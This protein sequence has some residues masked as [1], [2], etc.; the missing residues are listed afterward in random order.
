M[1]KL[2]TFSALCILCI[3]MVNAQDLKPKKDKATK[4]YG[5]VNKAKEFVIQPAWDDAEKFKDGFAIVEINKMKG[6]INEKGTV[7][8]E[9]QFYDIEKFKSNIA[10][11]VKNKK[12]GF[13]DNTGKILCEPKFDELKDDFPSGVFH[14]KIGEVW[15]L[16]GIGGK[17]LFEPQFLLRLDF[18]R[19]G[20]A[21]CAKKTGTETYSPTYYGIVKRDGSTVLECENFS[22]S[23]EGN[24][25]IISDKSGKW[26]I[27]DNNLKAIS[28]EFDNMESFSSGLSASRK[29]INDGIIAAKRDNKWGFINEKGETIIPFKFDEIGSE[30]YS[31]SQNLCAVKVGSKWGYI[32]KTGKYF[33]EPQFEEAKRFINALGA[34][35]AEV[36]L[37]G[38][39]YMLSD[40]GE[41]KLMPGQ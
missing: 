15:G 20:W 3:A 17:E 19:N 36:V 1:R 8:I 34:V 6:L 33:K 35:G 39:K 16:I 26:K 18:D 13:V 40:K 9:P 24:R 12:L 14:T 23:S 28:T 7:L 30:G 38:K 29:Y 2:V 37:K 32:D 22:I 4:K 25:Y 11:V 5:Y 27:Y 10:I 31:F 41:L 21:K